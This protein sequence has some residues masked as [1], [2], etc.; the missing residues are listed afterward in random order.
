M[1]QLHEVR[2]R[3]GKTAERITQL[4]RPEEFGRVFYD[5]NTKKPIKFTRGSLTHSEMCAPGST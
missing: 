4:L 3:E 1:G 2:V 5:R